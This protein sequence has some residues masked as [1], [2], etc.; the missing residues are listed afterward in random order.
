M[1]PHIYNLP[2][3]SVSYPYWSFDDQLDH[4]VRG[5]HLKLFPGLIACGRRASIVLE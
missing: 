1:Y 2:Y 3:H 4:F 5:E